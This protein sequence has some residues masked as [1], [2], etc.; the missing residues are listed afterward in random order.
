[1]KYIVLFS[2]STLLLLAGCG[3]KDGA[4]LLKEKKAKLDNLKTQIEQLEAEIAKLDSSSDK[5][6]KVVLVGVN[7]AIAQPFEHYIDLQAQISADNISY[8]AP[9]SAGMMAGGVVKEIFIRE[10]D[11]V[12]KGQPVLKL[13][14]AL[15]RQQ[16]ATSREQTNQLKTQL[17]FARNIYNRQKNLWDQG[18]GTEVQVLTA[19]NNVDALEHQLA[20]AEEG[21]KVQQEQLK[22]TTVV[23]DVAGIADEVN[24]RVGETFTGASATGAQIRIV[25][26]SEL[27]AI[28]NVPENYAGRIRK[29]AP[30]VIQ[31]SDL[32]K[33]F[34]SNL[35]LLSEAIDATKRGFRAEAKV[36]SDPQLRAN[37]LAVL[38]ILDYSNANAVVAP[39]NVIQS[40]EKGKFLFIA[41]KINATKTI[42]QKKYVELGEVYNGLVELKSGIAAG[43]PIITEGYQ[44]LYEGDRKSV[45]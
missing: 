10:G 40:D 8:I 13:D 41:A 28:T 9:R 1:M 14:D 16:I 42:A 39:V 34:K 35:S 44:N 36:P 45:V 18:I 11:A 6:V 37:Q 27:K 21:I 23:S 22:M 43:E 7:P 24:I 19:K 5:N 12:K 15:I 20:A 25:N 26:N 31:V 32:N 30:V 3:S 17:A 33:N 29:G 38:R 4:A 2:F